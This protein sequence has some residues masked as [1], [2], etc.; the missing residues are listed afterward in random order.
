MEFKA[1]PVTDPKLKAMLDKATE[2]ADMFLNALADMEERMSFKVFTIGGGL[3]RDQRNTILDLLMTQIAMR[4]KEVAP[5]VMEE[6]TITSSVEEG[7]TEFVMWLH[8]NAE[9]PA[10]PEAEV[11]F[12][13][14]DPKAEVVVPT[15]SIVSADDNGPSVIELVEGGPG[16][17]PE[18]NIVKE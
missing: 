2:A 7:E 9:K 13:H 15:I 18:E 17:Y 5:Q 6:K 10:A 12:A 1:P 16:T 11:P 3:T 8:A 14:F 4:I